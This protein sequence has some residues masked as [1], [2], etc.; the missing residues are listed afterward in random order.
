MPSSCRPRLTYARPF[1]AR[2]PATCLGTASIGRRMRTVR[3]RY[4]GLGGSSTGIALEA[5]MVAP[6]SVPAESATEPAGMDG[7]GAGM[8][9]GESDE[10]TFA[11][12]LR[13]RRQRRRP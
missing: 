2:K 7:V 1:K 11:A 9:N 10:A 5:L 13:M 6:A 12:E 4:S 3:D 8:G